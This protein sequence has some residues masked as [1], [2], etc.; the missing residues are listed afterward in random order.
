MVGC[1]PRLRRMEVFVSLIGG[2]EK[3]YYLAP[4]VLGAG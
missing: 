3:G 2:E 1:F 4:I